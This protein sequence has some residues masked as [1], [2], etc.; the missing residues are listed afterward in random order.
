RLRV[1]ILVTTAAL[2]CDENPRPPY[3]LGMIMLK[4]PFSRMKRQASSGRSLSSLLICH[5]S[6]IAH[7]CSTSPSTKPCSSDESAGLSTSNSF[8]QRGRPENSSASHQTVPAS[9]ASR[10][11]SEIDGIADLNQPNR[12]SET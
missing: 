4:K 7:N 8:F 10:S 1:A 11:V 3:S 6:S 9:S 2:P 5:S 12:R